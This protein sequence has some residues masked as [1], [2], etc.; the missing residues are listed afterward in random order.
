M[1]SALSKLAGVYKR[2]SRPARRLRFAASYFRGVPTTILD[3]ALQSREDSNF[4]YDITPRNRAYLAATVA[5]V[6]D[7]GR[8]DARAFSSAPDDDVLDYVAKAL[9]ALGLNEIDKSPSFS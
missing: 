5:I 6:M 4:S 8:D 9:A 7:I 2:C 3:W 1:T